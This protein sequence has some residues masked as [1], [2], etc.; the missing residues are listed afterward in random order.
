VIVRQIEIQDSATAQRNIGYQT[1]ILRDEVLVAGSPPFA[2]SVV[3]VASIAAQI[4]NRAPSAS[5]ASI[6]S[7]ASETRLPMLIRQR[8][9]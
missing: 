9:L 3:A 1:K 5:D 7:I 4:A 6:L 2:N 8:R